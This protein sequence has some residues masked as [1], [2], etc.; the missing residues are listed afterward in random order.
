MSG[1]FEAA[2]LVCFAISW[3]FNLTRAYRA[4]T[5]VGTSL[6]FMS[7]VFLGYLCG[8]ANKVVNDD[9]SYVLAFYLLDLGLVFMG[10]IIYGRNS[11]I[12]KKRLSG[13]Q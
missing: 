10:L 1:I 12:D 3:P 5:N 8:I 6:F 9:I 7:L 13:T 11:R 4:R 2:M